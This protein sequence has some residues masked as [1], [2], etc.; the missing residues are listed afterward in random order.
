[1]ASETEGKGSGLRLFDGVALVV[2]GVVGLLVAFW[3]LHFIAGLL[4][5]VVKLAVLAAIVGGVL[6]WLFG[7]SKS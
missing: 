7:R 1:M 2:V 4:W 3:V 6:W 5:D